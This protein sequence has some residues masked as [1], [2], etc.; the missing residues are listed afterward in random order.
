MSKGQETAADRL[1]KEK[2]DDCA[3]KNGA[4]VLIVIV[5]IGAVLS[6]VGG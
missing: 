4:I 3:T 5:A 1:W 2:L 6:I